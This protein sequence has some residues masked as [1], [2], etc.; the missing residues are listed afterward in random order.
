MSWA[1]ERR[2]STIASFDLGGA[3]GDLRRVRVDA[4]EEQPRSSAIDP[5][6]RFLIVAG[7]RSN[8]LGVY[9][10][11]SASGALDPRFR[12]PVGAKPVWVTVFA[13]APFN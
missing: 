8:H 9:A 11:D 5:R 10:I 3:K 2:A 4:T 1:S 6:G 12:F 7:E 13:P